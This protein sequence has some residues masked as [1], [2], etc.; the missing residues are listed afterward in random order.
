VHLRL[1]V[2]CML[3]A[4][5]L[6][7]CGGGGS[8]AVPTGQTPNGGGGDPQG[9]T[10][11]FESGAVWVAYQTRIDAFPVATSGSATP[12]ATLGAWPWS[13]TGTGATPGIVDLA[14]APDGTKWVLENRDFAL[15]GAGW[16][17]FAYAP[18]ATD[19]RPENSYGADT[20]TPLAIGIAGDGVMV[21]TV[22]TNGSYTI[23]TYPYASNFPAATR[24]FTSGS[25]I[26]SFAEGN[27]SK[28]Y[29]ARPDRVDVYLP[30]ADGSAAPLRSI[31]VA[32]PITTGTHAFCVGPDESIY[33]LAGPNSQS[34]P[35]VAYVDV[36]S[37]STGA[38]TRRIGPIPATFDPLSVRQ[39]IVVDAKNR[40]YIATN[41]QVY[42]Y[43]PYANGAATP[44]RVFTDS[45]A[46]Q[47]P[48]ALAVGPA[49]Q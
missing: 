18:P 21:E 41:G 16:R 32:V 47:Q 40:V 15:G 20:G 49:L 48:G 44:Q 1:A 26:V 36:Y 13:T 14:I 39:P 11:A 38:L 4:F 42:R 10:I 30:T 9:T 2:S 3:A 45:T 34:D 31:P 17:M 33:V 25:R 12:S 27:D 24:T 5:A 43:G 35:Q 22:D 37:P 28:L 19:T 29:V 7:A 6:T 8:S 46:Q 23:A